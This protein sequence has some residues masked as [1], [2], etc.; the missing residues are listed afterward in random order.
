MQEIEEREGERERESESESERESERA[1]EKEREKERENERERK[2]EMQE[3]EGRQ[4]CMCGCGGKGWGVERSQM[5][6]E[7]GCL[8]RGCV[9]E[10]MHVRACV[11]VQWSMS[12]P[13][14]N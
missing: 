12:R 1:W 4:G 2:R 14:P 5:E 7:R 11:L 13:C 3:I 6:H 10:H 8:G 9:C